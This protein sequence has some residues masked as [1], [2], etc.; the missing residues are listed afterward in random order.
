MTN[1]VVNKQDLAELAERARSGLIVPEALG[2]ELEAVL[3]T[4]KPAVS[5]EKIEQLRGLVRIKHRALYNYGRCT[6]AVHPKK[7]A[8][9]CNYC[10]AVAAQETPQPLD[11]KA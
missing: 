9:R 4:A 5:A 6:C 2:A 10:I 11:G 1:I 8:R 3:R 7:D